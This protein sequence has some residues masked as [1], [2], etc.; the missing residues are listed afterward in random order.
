[1]PRNRT[2]TR[3]VNL[4]MA[5]LATIALVRPQ[6]AKEMAIT[7]DDLP[8]AYPGALTLAEQREAVARVLA[9]LDKHRIT[10]M[11]FVIGGAVTEANHELLD[12]VVRAG[13]GMVSTASRI[14]IWGSSP[15]STTSSTSRRA[16]RQSNRG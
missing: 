14:R 16:K 15:P 9:A 4:V 7:F 1:V 2:H 5:L 12:M 3:A 11:A 10:A 8:F 6:G 13:H